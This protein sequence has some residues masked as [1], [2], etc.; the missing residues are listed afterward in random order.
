[1]RPPLL[2]PRATSTR[3]RADDGRAPVKPLAAVSRRVL[4]GPRLARKVEQHRRHAAHGFGGVPWPSCRAHC[5]EGAAACAPR[6]RCH[7]AS[8]PYSSV[9]IAPWSPPSYV[10]TSRRR[11]DRT[12]RSTRHAASPRGHDR[13]A[14]V[15]RVRAQRGRWPRRRRGPGHPRLPRLAAKTY[16]PPEPNVRCRAGQ[17]VDGGCR[18]PRA[19]CA[20]ITNAEL[21]SAPS[22][23]RGQQGHG[24]IL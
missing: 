17:L 7:S 20:R 21:L 22:L 24:G 13:H 6:D 11:I 16:T 10:T 19:D 4:P 1:M 23:W 18:A 5:A 9:L 15:D 3:N 12:I 2:T 8:G 14:A